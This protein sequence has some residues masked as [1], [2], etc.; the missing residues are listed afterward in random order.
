MVLT[1]DGEVVTDLDPVI[2]YMHR[3][4][5]KLPEN[6]DFRQA[7]GYH[8]R[9]DYLAQFNTEHCFVEAVEKLGGIVPTERAQYIRVIL[10]ELNRITSHLMFIGAF[11][12]D[13]GLFGTS[14]M[15]AFR[16]REYVQEFFEEI[17]GERMM[18]NYFRPGGVAWDVPENFS[19][20]CTE[21]L[22][23]IRSGIGDLEGLMI[24]NEVV[25][26]RCRGLSPMTP[27]EAINWGLSGPLLRATGL[28][29]DIR[30]AEPYS[31]YDR[32]EFDIPVGT[33]G[34]V[35][36][37]LIV[38]L[39]GDEAVRAHRRAGAGADAR[40][41]DHGRGDEAHPPRARR[42]G[43]HARREPA[44]RVRR[45]PRLHRHR[46]AVPPQGARRVL[47]QPLRPARDV[48]RP[49]RR[50]RH[51]DPRLDRHRA[52]RG[53]PMTAAVAADRR[54][55]SRPTPGW[56][57]LVRLAVVAVL[58]PVGVIF[59]TWLER[60]VIGRLQQRLGPMRVGPYGPAAGRRRHDQADHEGR[61]AARHGRPLDVRAGAVRDRRAGDHGAGGAAVHRGH[62]HPQHGAGPVLHRRRVRPLD[63]RLRDGRLGLRQQVRAARRRPRRRAA[64]Q[65][66]SAAD[67]RR[68]R[69][70]HAGP[71]AEPRRSSSPLQD[72]TPFIAYQPLG[73]IIFT[74][75]GLAELYRQPFDIPVAESEVVGGA[76]VEY[77]GIRWSMFQLGEFASLVLISI[78]G[79]ADLPRRLDLAVQ[80]RP[81]RL[82][83][84]AAD[85]RE[86]DR[87]SSSSSCGCG[88]AC[89][90]CASTS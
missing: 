35:Y 45:L 47:L 53:G 41:P 2:G 86:D 58:L 5:E 62:L 81:R 24:D 48:R 50:G 60:K 78:L 82:G 79:L 43:L 3:G 65:L 39:R 8:D 33:N 34:D 29:H 68:R 88:R 67:P 36:D 20:R 83:A 59:L 66:R 80:R 12:T 89:R 23:R 55:S 15:Y 40:R 18:Y 38:R 7:I 10:A 70:R 75:A 6:C 28:A 87:R 54:E 49:L 13:V 17:T 90:A 14:F 85:G 26:A 76:T 22:G 51:H 56:T 69:D 11:G 46:Q 61:R 19:E 42:R 30:R 4:N 32:F 84:G 52:V 27:E 57:P 16:D 71:D 37:R 1:V 74:I 63:R 64:H 25:L 21:M 73:F 9:T 77:S 72:D 44:R 31:I